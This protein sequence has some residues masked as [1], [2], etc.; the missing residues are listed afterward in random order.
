MKNIVMSILA[1]AVVLNICIPTPVSGADIRNIT[2]TWTGERN[3]TN[4]DGIITPSVFS[5]TLFN[6]SSRS[7]EGYCEDNTGFC[8]SV[9]GC[10]GPDN[11]SVL[12]LS[13]GGALCIGS[14]LG[15]EELIT[16]TVQLDGNVS[17]ERFLRNPALNIPDYKIEDITGWWPFLT[18]ESLGHDGLSMNTTKDGGGIR[19]A[20][21]SGRL[22]AGD[23]VL[24]DQSEYSLSGCLSGDG[25]TIVAKTTK[26]SLILGRFID[27]NTGIL[28]E[29]PDDMTDPAVRT[30]RLSRDGQYAEP[31]PNPP[32]LTGFWGVTESEYITGPSLADGSEYQPV[33]LSI[34]IHEGS[35]FSGDMD[36]AG[37]SEQ[38]WGAFSDD[39]RSLLMK[40]EDGGVILGYLHEEEMKGVIIRPVGHSLIFFSAMR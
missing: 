15:S 35:H 5:Y 13:E 4:F 16:A 29:L 8:Q 38:I 21:Q 20:N 32:D 40:G 2:G 11:R 30:W 23:L 34:D 39:G 12:M 27:G 26:P 1:F 3:I 25:M 9:I 31:V 28:H 18:T 14:F 7:F 33:T 10:I 36:Y 22:C 17:I 24:P 19:I 6:Q 37:T